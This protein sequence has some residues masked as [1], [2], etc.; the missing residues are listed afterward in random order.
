MKFPGRQANRAFKAIKST[1]LR[2][3][4]SCSLPL[5]G[6]LIKIATQALFLLTVGQSVRLSVLFAHLSVRPSICLAV[7]IVHA[8]VR[9][10]VC[11]RS[12]APAQTPVCPSVL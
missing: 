4:A 1:N 5:L 2:L 8:C 11:V 10:C 3:I 12:Q 9:E 6:I 7:L